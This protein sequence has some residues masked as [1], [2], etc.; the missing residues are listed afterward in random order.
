LARDTVADPT[1]SA[2][3]H[4][5]CLAATRALR[6]LRFPLVTFVLLDYFTLPPSARGVR[7]DL[8]SELRIGVGIC[9]FP[10]AYRPYA[11]DYARHTGVTVCTISFLTSWLRVFSFLL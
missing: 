1:G 7:R 2:R 11:T 4:R 10:Y 3:I 6:H 9:N 8:S 5:G